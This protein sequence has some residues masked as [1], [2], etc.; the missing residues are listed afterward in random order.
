M[1]TMVEP[2]MLPEEKLTTRFD[3]LASSESH[4]NHPTKKDYHWHRDDS[5][6]DMLDKYDKYTP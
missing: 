2:Y 1:S 6:W 5:D 4:S 3:N